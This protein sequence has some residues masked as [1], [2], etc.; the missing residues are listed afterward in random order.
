LAP[1]CKETAKDDQR[2]VTSLTNAPS[3]ATSKWK[4]QWL[5]PGDIIPSCCSIVVPFNLH[6][7]RL[8][9]GVVPPRSARPLRKAH[10][11]TTTAVAEAAA[12]WLRSGGGYQRDERWMYGRRLLML[13]GSQPVKNYG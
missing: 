9:T 12:C 11:T 5:Q 7:D 2:N 13:L 3:S 10:S 4:Q 6:A 8:S 1:T